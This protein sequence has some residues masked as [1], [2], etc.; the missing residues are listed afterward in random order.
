MKNRKRE[1]QA[2]QRLI[3]ISRQVEGLSAGDFLRAGR[4]QERFFWREGGKPEMVAGFGL[5]AELKAWGKNRFR[6][7]ERQARSLFA[8]ALILGPNQPLAAPRLAG[9]FA[10]R[11]DFIP[12][13]TWAVFHPAHFILPHFQLSQSGAGCWLT[14]NALAALEEEV[15]GVIRCLEEALEM[16]LQ[17]LLQVREEEQIYPERAMGASPA[18]NG[19]FSGL[20]SEVQVRYPMAPEDWAEMVNKAITGIRAGEMKKVVLARMCEIRGQ[21][22]FVI[23]TALRFLD[24]RYEGC[25]R[26]LFE[27]RP[28]H[29][30]FGATPELLVAVQG[31][32]LRTMALAG[33]IRRGA[34]K[35]EDAA[36]AEELLSSSKDRHEH[37]LVVEALRRKLAGRTLASSIPPEPSI[38][39]LS[40]IMHLYT[41][42]QARLRS[43]EGVLPLA[44]H[45]HP[46]PALGGA[47]RRSALAFIRAEEPVT[48]GWYAGPVGWIDPQLDGVFSV[49]IRSAVVQ[50]ERAWLYAGGGIVADS[51]PEK[52]WE[53]TALKFRPMLQALGIQEE[54]LSQV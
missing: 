30:F 41:P 34:S 32:A 48:R 46:T 31:D 52:E 5:A 18:G 9:G 3:S 36:L 28:G 45:L 20:K 12:D 13:N 8:G 17:W 42:I 47:P 27:P 4:G 29:I 40:N 14:I 19:F 53:E 49:A 24:E 50:H 26:F 38:L 2:A 10:F 51:Q 33:S 54:V 39:A 6:E 35:E 16:R 11:D 44:A 15:Q 1:S 25:Y 22:D 37:R 21:G 7:I 23:E 43:P